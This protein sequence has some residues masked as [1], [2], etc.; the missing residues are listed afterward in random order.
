MRTVGPELQME[1]R[2]RAFALRE[3]IIIIAVIAGLAAVLLPAMMKAKA[4]SSR[5]GCVNNLK[6][7]SLSFQQ[8]GLDNDDRFPMQ[9]SVTNGG[10]LELVPKGRVY[11]H[12]LVM[13][14]ELNTPRVLR[15]TGDK[16][17]TGAIDFNA[18]FN[19]SQ[20]SYFVGVDAEEA[21]P[22]ML[23]VGDACFSIARKPINPGLHHL[24]PNTEVGWT[25][26]YRA[27]HEKGGNIGLADGS[28]TAPD[29]PAFRELLRQSGD[30]TNR[31]AVP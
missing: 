27:R 18:G 31:V 25:K 21:R 23:L 10:T 28:V 29:D 7:I 6:Q 8:W 22:Q 26:P 3:V 30:L 9:V 2:V 1:A 4:R 12:F 16:E 24:W 5:L 15:C 20:I 19:D 11:P 14:N 13:S 17:R